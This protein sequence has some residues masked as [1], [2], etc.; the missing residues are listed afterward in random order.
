MLCYV[1]LVQL[2]VPTMLRFMCQEYIIPCYIDIDE[3]I[4]EWS[5]PKLVLRYANNWHN[6][7]TRLN[8]GI[9]IQ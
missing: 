5:N 7:N 8:A 3:R 1:E 6:P 2:R 9:I 4:A